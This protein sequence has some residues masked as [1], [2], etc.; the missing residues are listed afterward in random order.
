MCILILCARARERERKTDLSIYHVNS[1]SDACMAK[2]KIIKNFLIE[3]NEHVGKK[4][5]ERMRVKHVKNVNVNV[6]AKGFDINFSQ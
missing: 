4:N 5:E 2:K 3:W 6:S 1:I